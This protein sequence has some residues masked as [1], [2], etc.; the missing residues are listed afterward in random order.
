M[1]DTDLNQQ[2][3]EL[4]PPDAED[5]VLV[6]GEASVRST[7]ILTSFSVPMSVGVTSETQR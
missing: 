7:D 6:K 1:T 3:D 2:I 4:L 5:E